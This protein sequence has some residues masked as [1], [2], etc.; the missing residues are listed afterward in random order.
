M[1]RDNKYISVTN[2]D[3]AYAQSILL[4][5]GGSFDSQKR[6]FIK[7]L[8]TIDL[9]A[10]PGSGKTLALLAKLLIL[11]KYMPFPG[12]AGVLVIS[13]TNA[14]IDEI[15]N[16]IGPHCPKLFAYPNY[17]GTIQSFVDQ[18]LAIPC[19]VNEYKKKPYR[20]D[21]EIYYEKIKNF[22]TYFFPGFSHDEDRR[23]KYFLR[24][25]DTFL[26]NYRFRLKNGETVLV[27]NING[28]EVEIKKPR[29][30]TR[31]QNY[32]DFSDAE[33]E[34]VKAWLFR[35]KNRLLSDGI[36]HF[37]DAYYL[38]AKYLLN[39]PR[40]KKILQKRFKYVFVDEMQDMD[41]H[42]Y[43]ILEK[44]FYKKS[45]KGHVY[46]RI[47]DKNQSIY[48]DKVKLE[49]VWKDREKILK[50]TGSYRLTPEV[51][52]V[53]KYF[54]L[55]FEE[56]EGKRIIDPVIKPRIIVYGD[57]TITEVIP[58]YAEIIRGLG[59][60]A[61][62]RKP[63]VAIGWRKEH[64]EA[65]KYGIKNYHT[66]FEANRHRQKIDYSNLKSYLI[67]YDRDNKALSGIRKNIINGFLKILRFEKKLDENDK[68]FTIKKLLLYL[69][70]SH[71]DIFKEFQLKLY[72]WCVE[73]AKGA[74]D[75]TAQSI[76]NYLPVFM[77]RIFGIEDL[78]E[79][80]KQFIENDEQ[81]P[82]P[83]LAC[84]VDEN[85]NT[86]SLSC[87]GTN[88]L[89]STVHSIKGKTNTATLYM[90]T[91][92]RGEYESARLDRCFKCQLPNF[93]ANRDKYKKESIKMVYVG[94]SRPTHLLCFAVHKERFDRYFHDLVDNQDWVLV[95]DLVN[96]QNN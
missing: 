40:I 67:Y 45:V 85:M 91:S 93:R 36:V 11:E 33:K 43:D 76:R 77:Q 27:K 57:D 31:A 28:K 73:D 37:D 74:V 69:K 6:D 80:S 82:A 59:L 65:G 2:Q 48:S 64:P 52:K 50:L 35:L 29:G 86:N 60:T 16:K 23:A 12:G 51:A 79:Q 56:I 18:F 19:Y 1:W 96:D 62:K 5:R 46:Q 61:T 24:A 10:V 7:N 94:F 58:K 75:Q 92:Y 95:K 44:L 3:I 39:F 53:V 13:H 81:L 89:V 63:F 34:R 14:A 32:T 54:G 25:N 83:V 47:G 9:Q 4:G 26:Y 42:Q 22:S 68:H 8:S 30:R 41:V 88:I 38:A 21:D 55:E 71:P 90:E 87:D 84:A 72:K 66:Q 78:N 70:D 20:I 15:V 49:S 17:V